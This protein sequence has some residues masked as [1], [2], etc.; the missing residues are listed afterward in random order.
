MRVLIGSAYGVTSPVK[1]CSNTLY[2]EASLQAG[3]VLMLPATVAERA[4]YVTAG[5]VRVGEIMLDAC[6]MAALAPGVNVNL[7]A[8]S[9]T[10]RAIVGG[11][12]LGKRHVWWNFASSRTE[13]IEQAKADWR[14]GRFQVV[15]GDEQEFIPLPED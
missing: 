1:T 6:T 9:E 12:P 7:Q 5:K 10:R 13:R 2:I 8:E 11:E 3:Q 15:P 4:V 14:A